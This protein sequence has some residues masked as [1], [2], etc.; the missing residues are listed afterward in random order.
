VRR[1]LLA[2]IGT[3]GNSFGGGLVVVS[4]SH[5]NVRACTAVTVS[6]VVM[7]IVYSIIATSRYIENES[8]RCSQHARPWI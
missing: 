4:V 5:F 8:G 1:L 6:V 3:L 2:L 7:I